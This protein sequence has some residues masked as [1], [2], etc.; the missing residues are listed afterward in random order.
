MIK[1]YNSGTSVWDDYGPSFL[2]TL[3]IL[4]DGNGDNLSVD[5]FGEMVGIT[6]DGNT[7]VV[8]A[9]YSEASGGTNRGAVFTYKYKI[10]SGTEWSATPN[11]VFKD[12]DSHKQVVVLLGVNR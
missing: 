11:L 6:G 7:I 9:R 5:R 2:T 1:K 8:G 4:E 10:P 12:G 3:P